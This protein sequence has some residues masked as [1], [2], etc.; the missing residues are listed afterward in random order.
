MAFLPSGRN[1]SRALGIGS[2][3]ISMKQ[4][5][6]Q[7]P[8]LRRLWWIGLVL[9]VVVTP[10]NAVPAQDVSIAAPATKSELGEMIIVAGRQMVRDFPES[11]YNHKTRIDPTV[12]ICEVDCS[13]FVAVVVK[14][15]SP[16]HIESLPLKKS[17]RKR[18]LAEDFYAGFVQA[19]EGKL[20]GWKA[21]KHVG[22]AQPG[23]VLAWYKEDHKKGENTGHVMLIEERPVDEGDGRWRIRIIDSTSTPHAQDTRPT[24]K[25]GLG[26]G[27]IWL[28]VDTDRHIRGYRWKS[29]S[30]KLSEHPVAIGRAVKSIPGE[31]P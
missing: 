8:G 20:P 14:S 22:D 7:H 24:G 23:D 2:G 29:K 25:T 12:G 15:V 6:Q 1:R 26:I 9:A 3:K 19:A 13:G 16:A 31:Q 11:S 18:P 5:E 30:G 27:T 17:G 21:I 10:P 4:N 28:E